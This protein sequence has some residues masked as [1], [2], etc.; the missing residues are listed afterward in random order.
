M[1]IDPKRNVFQRFEDGTF[2]KVNLDSK[3]KKIDKINIIQMDYL[4]FGS[5]I[6]AMGFE[7]NKKI[8]SIGNPPFGKHLVLWQL[9]FLTYVLNFVMQSVL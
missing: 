7:T 5:A 8:I 4:S 6:K 3:D 9:S 1:D 2:K